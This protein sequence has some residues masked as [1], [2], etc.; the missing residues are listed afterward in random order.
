MYVNFHNVIPRKC[1]DSISGVSPRYGHFTLFFPSI[2]YD[3]TNYSNNSCSI[4]VL[5]FIC[6]HCD[7]CIEFIQDISNVECA[8][9]QFLLIQHLKYLA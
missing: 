2:I 9:T 7:V 5:H 1:V 8:N 4:T 6:I 3:F